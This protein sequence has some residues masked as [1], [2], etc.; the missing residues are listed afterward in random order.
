MS[1]CPGLAADIEAKKARRAEL[2]R[3]M[4]ELREAMDALRDRIDTLREKRWK[5][6][7]EWVRLNAELRP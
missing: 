3:E 5:K 7:L 6:E 1:D 4:T 2:E